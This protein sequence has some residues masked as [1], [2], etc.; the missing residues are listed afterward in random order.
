MKPV[1]DL[2]LMSRIAR[3]RCLAVALAS[4]VVFPPMASATPP[5]QDWLSGG[6]A[7]G[8]WG[9]AR[10][11]LEENGLDVQVNYTAE[12][13][14]RQTDAVAYRGNLDLLLQL[15]AS[16][17]KLW[18]GGIVFV[19]GQDGHG[20]GVSGSPGFAMPVSNYEGP[21][22]TQLSEFWLYQVLPGG[23][24]LRL[25]KQDANRDFAAPRFGGN[26]MN[27]SFGV[28]PT[29]PMPSYPAP[30]LGVAAFVPLSSWMDARAGA[31][32]GD[33]EIESFGAHAF[34]GSV[35]AIAA[36][37]LHAGREGPHD[38]ILQIGGWY[39]DDPDRSGAFAI[40]DTLIHLAPQGESD[41]RNVQ[42]FVRGNWEPDA[43]APDAAVYVGG[44]V[45]A[46]GFIGANNTIGLGV[47]Y[48]SVTKADQGFV[49]LFFKWRRIEW[50][51]IEPDLQLY[52]LGGRTY[53]I[54]GLR[55]KLKI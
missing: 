35:F 16:K 28:L 50:F 4:I 42:F 11:L 2:A 24:A 37:N 30:A 3:D 17:A 10:S 9:G 8:D 31:Y 12:T 15:D 20:R 44:G 18:D 33:P 29:A 52:F 51:T 39:H 32:E 23:A 14:V 54:G 55:C 49:E 22:F 27:S 46:N 43:A 1:R 26:F 47:G 6:H 19:Y 21:S 25:G 40:A 41:H 34:D 53:T 38:T 5:E 48:V 7:T 13:F 45:T 36:A